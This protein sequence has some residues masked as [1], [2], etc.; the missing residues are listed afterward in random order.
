MTNQPATGA[1][2]AKVEGYVYWWDPGRGK[3]GAR[4]ARYAVV[5]AIPRSAPCALPCYQGD[6]QT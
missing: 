1:A 4:G 5:K 2:T 6:S 3:I